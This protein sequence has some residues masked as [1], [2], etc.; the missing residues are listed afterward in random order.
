MG[1]DT[2]SNLKLLSIGTY[3]SASHNGQRVIH[4]TD[5]GGTQAVSQLHILSHVMEKIS[6]DTNSTFH[7][8]VK[9]PC[10]V[11]DAIGGTGT[12]G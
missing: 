4:G 1:I 11:F 2:K 7:G 12:G 3:L 6:C 9:R 5:A 8:A 10:E